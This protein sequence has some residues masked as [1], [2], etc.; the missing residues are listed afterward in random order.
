MYIYIYIYMYIYIYIWIHAQIHICAC[1][2]PN[3]YA[4]NIFYSFQKT[5]CLCSIWGGEQA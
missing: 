1:K 3:I 4:H 2:S 5:T